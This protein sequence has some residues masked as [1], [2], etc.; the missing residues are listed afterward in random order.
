M[1]FRSLLSRP[2]G[3]VFS[4]ILY[5]T[6]HRIFA[7]EAYFAKHIILGNADPLRLFDTINGLFLEQSL[8]R[9]TF[10][11]Q[12][13]EYVWH[14]YCHQDLS[15]FPFL[16]LSAYS[17]AWIK[18]FWLNILIPYYEDINPLRTLPFRFVLI[19]HSEKIFS[20]LFLMDES[21]HD[22][23]GE[24]IICQTPNDLFHQA[25]TPTPQPRYED[26]L[27]YL[28]SKESLSF[29]LNLFDFQGHINALRQL[30]QHLET[31]PR[32]K[33]YAHFSVPLDVPEKHQNRSKWEIAI[34][35]LNNFCKRYLPLTTIPIFMVDDCRRFDHDRFVNTV[36]G[37]G[38]YRPLLLDVSM[39]TATLATSLHETLQHYVRNGLHFL[40]LLEK[41]RLPPAY[42]EEPLLRKATILFRFNAHYSA[43][44]SDELYDSVTHQLHYG[45]DL[46][47]WG[48]GVYFFVSF[49]SNQPF[50][51][52]R[53]PFEVSENDLKQLLYRF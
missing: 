30:S 25:R 8:L 13:N 4:P 38:D 11:K 44:Q 26:Y 14:E 42:Q 33:I 50:L 39:E 37:F 28:Q 45:P 31:L 15:H 49:K 3:H 21:I 17:P 27:A 32:D 41:N 18:A 16:D 1:L 24:D 52:V 10:T 23:Y 48:E 51:T 7:R 35:L 53:T 6:N 29:D 12:D 40:V 20:I 9:S 22:T 46:Q 5:K 19:K 47:R 36:G 43:I 2:I 34:L